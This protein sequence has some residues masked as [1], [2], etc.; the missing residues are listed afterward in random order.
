MLVDMVFDVS[1]GKPLGSTA[2][3]SNKIFHDRESSVSEGV[4]DPYT[5]DVRRSAGTIPLLQAPR[6]RNTVSSAAPHWF[7]SHAPHGVIR[8]CKVTER[9]ALVKSCVSNIRPRIVQ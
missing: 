6:A 3:V 9:N 4:L 2:G 8:T 5:G 1:N 7:A